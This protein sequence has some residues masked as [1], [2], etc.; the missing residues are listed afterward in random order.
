MNAPQFASVDDQ[1]KACGAE[2][3][4]KYQAAPE[5][6]RAAFRLLITLPLTD[7]VAVAAGMEKCNDELGR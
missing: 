4:Q 7:M 6:V 1:I 5:C 3:W 2:F